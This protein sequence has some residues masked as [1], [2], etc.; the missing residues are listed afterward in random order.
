MFRILASIAAGFGAV[1]MV[2]L[3]VTPPELDRMPT[4]A[5][6]PATVTAP[7]Q[8]EM[9]LPVSG[10][11]VLTRRDTAEFCVIERS[12]ALVDGQAP[13]MMDE[14]CTDLE[15]ALAAVTVWK[16]VAGRIV[17]ADENGQVIVA[18]D[19]DDGG[20]WLSKGD[21]PGLYSLAGI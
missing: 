5:I 12:L 4:G 14:D 16:E 13:I 19:S 1:W 6:A 9:P 2:S 20:S 21:G 15:P 10:L 8:A 3:A 7:P 11:F 18:F 17:L